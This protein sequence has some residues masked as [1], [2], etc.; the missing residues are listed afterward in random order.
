MTMLQTGTRDFELSKN[1]REELAF[2]DNDELYTSVLLM[3]IGPQ[4]IVVRAG[5]S[6]HRLWSRPES[7]GDGWR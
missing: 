1:E 5:A 7:G 4:Q 6:Y 2:R 3:S